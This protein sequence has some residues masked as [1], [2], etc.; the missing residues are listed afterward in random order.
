MPDWLIIPSGESAVR[1]GKPQRCL[2]AAIVA[3]RNVKDIATLDTVGQNKA[4]ELA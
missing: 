4:L 3:S 1:E 2:R